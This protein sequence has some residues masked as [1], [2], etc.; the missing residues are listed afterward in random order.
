MRLLFFACAFAAGA[1]TVSAAPGPSLAN[2]DPNYRALRENDIKETFLVENLTFQRDAGD[3]R[4]KKGL[5]SFTGPVLGRVAQAVFQGEGEFFLKP[6]LQLERD[7][8]VAV[9]GKP[10]LAETFQQAV[11]LFTDLTYQEFRSGVSA[12]PLD[13]RARDLLREFRER[14][15]KEREGSNLDAEILADLYNSSRPGAFRAFIRGRRYDDLRFVHAPLGAVPELPAPEEVAVINADPES[16]EAG[17]LY[18][19]HF[20]PEYE[21]GTAGSHED[22]RK[23][24]A[25]AYRIDTTIAGNERLTAKTHVRLKAVAGGDGVIALGLLPALRVTRV[26]LAG[27]EVPFIQEDRRQD[28][29]FYIVLPEPLVR[30]GSYEMEIEYQGDKVIADAGGGNFA[31]GARTSWYPSLNS[32]QDRATYDLTFRVPKRYTLVSVGNL[33]KESREGD[34]AVS[35]WVSEIPLAVAGF[36]YGDFKKK[37]IVDQRTGYKI[38]GYAAMKLP[39][40]LK[41]AEEIGGM[42]PSR[43]I[44]KTLSEAQAS[45]QVFEHWFGKAP[46]GRVAITQQPQPNFGQSWPSLVFMPLL[47]YLDATQ[48][49]Q[50]MGQV[51]DRINAFVTEVT[52]HEVAHQWWGHIVGWASF[53]DQW[54][55]EGFADFSASLY[56]QAIDKKPDRFLKF[57][58][59]HRRR[60]LEKNNFGQAPNDAGPI[61]MGLRLSTPKN[62]GAYSALVYPKGAYVLHM[63]RYLMWDAKSGDESFRTMMHDFVE[64]HLHKNA[65]TESFK[66]VVEK[67]LKPG[68]DLDGNGRLD[69]FFNQWV[70]GTGIPRY[71]FDYTLAPAGGEEVLLSATLTQ[72]DV[73]AGFRMPV[74]VYGD[75]DGRLI[76]LGSVRMA[77]NTTFDGIKVKLPKKPRRVF[78]NAFCNVL[79]KK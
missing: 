58:E 19:A 10:T 43:L 35:Q 64:T 7:Y 55:S 3:F 27:R 45:V 63:L 70:Y 54:L 30:N 69:W 31:V 22:K 41:G 16:R 60:I 25:E 48:R 34:Y 77:G 13:P 12:A 32:F 4:L 36:N 6:P 1:A 67:H 71:K 14:M 38:E 51:S 56:L 46:Y 73:S 50:L 15:R 75:F 29:D 68:M 47:A 57:W 78:I 18:H 37:E 61:W 24:A 42:S 20:V 11:F 8:L 59:D 2:S 26:A 74:P 76:S 66:A 72:S 5:L 23:V 44:D 39:D 17:I 9:T 28:G 49:W 40:Y 52:A 79:E 33:I 21:K 65:S 53:H 62:P